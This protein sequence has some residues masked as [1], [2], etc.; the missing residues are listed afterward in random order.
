MKKDKIDH[1]EL[2]RKERSNITKSV[3]R[4]VKASER[5]MRKKGFVIKK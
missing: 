4:I 5:R 1:L 2:T 3:G